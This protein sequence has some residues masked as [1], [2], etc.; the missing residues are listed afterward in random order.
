MKNPLT[1]NLLYI[2]L[3]VLAL[4]TAL[5]VHIIDRKEPTS[6]PIESA[7]DGKVTA[8]ST[9]LSEE[10][11]KAYLKTLGRPYIKELRKT[12]D[13]YNEGKIS[14]NDIINSDLIV[15]PEA[16]GSG[17]RCGLKSFN[18]DYFKS[19][20]MV[21]WVDSGLGGGLIVDI[22]FLN[23]P[24][25]VFSVWV[26]ETSSGWELRSFCENKEFTPKDIDEIWMKPYHQYHL[27]PEFSV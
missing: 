27:K 25:K 2:L 19:K 1:Y 7:G 6:S 14:E 3:V 20:F 8:T 5:Y 17:T 15:N 18:P 9:T 10:D 22:I 24:D 23:K 21:S 16:S 4:S 13:N 12:L 11:I 26:Y